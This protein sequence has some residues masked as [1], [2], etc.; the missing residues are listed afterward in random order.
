MKEVSGFPSASFFATGYLTNVWPPSQY[1]TQS[2][3]SYAASTPLTSVISNDSK[4]AMSLNAITEIPVTVAGIG[5][6]RNGSVSV[7]IAYVGYGLALIISGNVETGKVF[8]GVVA[9]YLIGS[10][11]ELRIGIRRGEIRIYRYVAPAV[12][13][14]QARAVSS[15]SFSPLPS[16]CVYQPRKAAPSPPL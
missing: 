4:T 13:L 12:P 1:K 9:R 8:R 11:V 15:V 5:Y 7:E 10:V 3:T 16:F 6:V 14:F 2:I